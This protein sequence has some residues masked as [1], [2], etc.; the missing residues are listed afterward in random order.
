MTIKSAHKR[1]KSLT[2]NQLIGLSPLIISNFW[3]S[4]GEDQKPLKNMSLKCL[5]EN[6]RGEIQI[7]SE[8]DMG[9]MYFLT[10]SY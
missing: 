8:T 9:F 7:D 3:C 6:P 2:S 1:V 4:E 10:I 5:M